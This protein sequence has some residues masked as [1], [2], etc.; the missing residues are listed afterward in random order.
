MKFVRALNAIML[1]MLYFFFFES[2]NNVSVN[3]ANLKIRS[4]RYVIA[5]LSIIAFLATIDVVVAP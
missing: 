3:S 2:A 4:V 1:I 5:Y